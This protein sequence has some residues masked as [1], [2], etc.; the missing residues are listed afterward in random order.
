MADRVLKLVDG[1]KNISICQKN[2]SDAD[3]HSYQKMADVFISLHRSEGYGLNIKECLEHGIPTL[4]TAWSGN[5]DYMN[6]YPHS[7]PIDY[8]LVEYQDP[9]HHYKGDNLIWAEPNIDQAAETLCQVYSLWEA[10]NA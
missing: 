2:F 3:M 6:T 10:D 4:A 1:R 9:T 7:F 8:H 5:M